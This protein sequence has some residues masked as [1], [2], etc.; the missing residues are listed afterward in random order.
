MASAPNWICNSFFEFE[1]SVS[2]FSFNQSCDVGFCSSNFILCSNE[3][4]LFL[5]PSE[6]MSVYKWE[7]HYDAL[8]H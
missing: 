5:S 4:V 3:K 8:D 6:H 1:Y 7:K 2:L